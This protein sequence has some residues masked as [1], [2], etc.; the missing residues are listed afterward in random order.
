MRIMKINSRHLAT[1]LFIVLLTA[2]MVVFIYQRALPTTYPLTVGSVSET[3][4]LARG[5]VVD[6]SATEALAKERAEQVS[7]V[8]SRSESISASAVDS[9]K[10]LFDAADAERTV[11]LGKARLLP[12]TGTASTGSANAAGTGGSDAAGSNT[13]PYQMDPVLV[14]QSVDRLKQ[15]IDQ[16]LGV[17]PENGVLLVLLTNERSIY[18]SIK[19]KTLSLAD[20]IMQGKNDGPAITAQI[21]REV[22]KQVESVEFYKNDYAAI[23]PILS[24]FLKPNVVYDEA[25]TVKAR[26]AEY[27]Q[28][29][30]NPI[31]IPAGTRLVS[32]GEVI[33]QNTY[34][35]LMALNM[36]DTGQINWRF[37]AGV[38][39]LVV[40]CTALAS[41]YLFFFERAGMQRHKDRMVAMVLAILP[42]LMS[43]WLVRQY[44]SAAPIYLTTILLTMYFNLR[45][46]LVISLL[47]TAMVTPLTDAAAQFLF[48][49][50]LGILVSGVL[51]DLYS[52]R[53]H[54]A[55]LILGTAGGCGAAALL[56]DMVGKSALSIAATNAGVAALSGGL[57]AV[58]AIGLNP[59]VELFLSTVSPMKL[60]ELAQSNQP[61]LRKLFL[62][63]PGTY[64]HSMMVA[65]L[66]EAA[67]DAIGANALLVRVGAYYHDI[68]K[69]VNPY[70]FTENQSMRNPHD[71]LTPQRSSEIIIAHVRNGLD[72]ARKNRIPLPIQ[73][74]IMEHHGNQTQA[75]FFDKACRL[76]AERGEPQPSES[77]FCYPWPVPTGP[78]SA[79]VMMADSCEAAMKSNQVDNLQD[80]ETLI[81]RII[82]KKI[83]TDQLVESGLSFADVEKAIQAFLRVYAGQFHTRVRYPDDQSYPNDQSNHQQPGS[84]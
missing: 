42:V 50:S 84:R 65:N 9:I 72:I 78:E 55:S 27:N 60:L 83:N 14:Q 71:D 43:G 31:M 36:I 8:M 79:I 68:G 45:T 77:D 34:D 46:G 61:L 56:F 69:T 59:I 13:A 41:L 54:Y 76:A 17:T 25:A 64:Q 7:M 52:R 58:L 49:S 23:A 67:A 73:R 26:E 22:N 74:I 32:A 15:T 47:M 21:E 81:R 39:M 5:A 19:T 10:R 63:A 1:A 29:L 6:R 30:N 80:A 2:L 4:I 33:D 12:E 38:L 37:F 62:E 24:A 11:L 82:K 40:L 44:P 51:T 35:Q 20:L 70:M 66:A 3:D 28:I 57:S 48:V 16:E 75:Y 53:S 18:E